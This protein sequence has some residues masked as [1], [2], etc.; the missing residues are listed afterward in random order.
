MSFFYYLITRLVSSDDVERHFAYLIAIIFLNSA[1][2]MLISPNLKILGLLICE[3]WSILIICLIYIIY[4]IQLIPRSYY[5]NRVAEVCKF[6][7]FII[8]SS[9]LLIFYF[10]SNSVQALRYNSE[11]FL[12]DSWLLEIDTI[13]LP[14]FPK[15]QLALYLDTNKIYGVTTRISSIYVEILQWCYVSYYFW[16]NL[17]G[18]YLISYYYQ[19]IESDK[20]KKRLS[21]RLIIMFLTAWLS[22]FFLNIMLN[23]FFPAVSPRIYLKNDYQNQLH[24]ILFY[25]LFSQNI[26][27]MASN[28]FGA[29][30]SC[31]CGLS[32]L[33]VV[34]AYRLQMRKFLI[35]SIIIGILISIATLVLRY[36]YFVDFL[37]SV[38]IVIFGSIMGGF[39]NKRTFNKFI[40][41]ETFDVEEFNFD[42][43]K[44]ENNTE[45]I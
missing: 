22:G 18:I 32:W 27:T 20:Q 3:F 38:V 17:L 24:G 8:L 28:T 43:F 37:A 25:D 30:P 40:E 23:L 35:F 33:V 14:F 7:L 21:Y 12:W 41:L 2:Y 45:K 4:Y 29:F 11:N 16:G 36:H 9:T 15:G 34:L 5:I 13:I 44:K 6:V 10:G 19:Y 31:H 39:H 42:I 26:N 1:I